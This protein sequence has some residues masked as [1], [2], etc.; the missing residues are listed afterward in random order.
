[1][2]GVILLT[3]AGFW[4]PLL[5]M[6]SFLIILVIVYAIRSRGR[7]GYRH[8]TDQTRPFFSGNISPEEG[9]RSGNLYWGFFEATKKYYKWLIRMHT[10]IVNDY[11][12][13]FVVL[14]LV[15]L[16]AVALGGL[17]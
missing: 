10:G 6:L 2:M 13:C 17:V 12:Y 9:I 16:A 8:G 4:N 1:M 14:L 3:E 11:V 7:K 5:W 15:I